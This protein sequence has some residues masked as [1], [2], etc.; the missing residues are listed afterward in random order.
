MKMFIRMRDFSVKKQTYT[1]KKSVFVKWISIWSVFHDV[2]AQSDQ[3]VLVA[4]NQVPNKQCL[5]AFLIQNVEQTVDGL[6]EH[7][8]SVFHLVQSS[9]ESKVVEVASRL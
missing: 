1:D 6:T 4:P 9:L 8:G 5:V 2:S 3:V 7:F